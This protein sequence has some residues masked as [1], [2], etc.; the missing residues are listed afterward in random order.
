M[1]KTCDNKGFQICFPNGLTL[2][3]QFGPGNYGSN[4]G[5]PFLYGEKPDREAQTV[6]I[7]VFET[8]GKGAWRTKEIAAAAGFDDPADDVMGYVGLAD[9]LKILNATSNYT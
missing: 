1:F 6:E 2:S 5:A 9:W 7:A 4:R 8:E 3:T